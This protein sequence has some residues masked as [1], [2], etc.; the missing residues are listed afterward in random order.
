MLACSAAWGCRPLRTPAARASP[1]PPGAAQAMQNRRFQHAMERSH[2]G[3]CSRRSHP[4]RR[5]LARCPTWALCRTCL[6][7]LATPHTSTLRTTGRGACR[8]WGCRTYW[9]AREALLLLSTGAPVPAALTPAPPAA[10][11]CLTPHGPLHCSATP[12]KPTRLPPRP[13]APN[14]PTPPHPHTP[15]QPTHTRAMQH[16]T[17]T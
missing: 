1:T 17:V 7:P 8:R 16:S 3:G 9:Q 11:T 15:N 12:A 14:I 4:R 13:H 2:M 10:D 5:G 6:C